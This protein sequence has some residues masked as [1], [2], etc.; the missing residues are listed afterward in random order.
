MNIKQF[1]EGLQNQIY[2]NPVDYAWSYKLREHVP[3]ME[4]SLMSGN[5]LAAA[6]E[7]LSQLGQQLHQA[8]AEKDEITAFHSVRAIMDWGK[9]YYPQGPRRMNQLSVESLFNNGL[10]VQEVSRNW[11]AIKSADSNS[12]TLMNSAWTKVWA[13]L[14]PQDFII[15]DDRVCAAFGL[16]VADFA[17]LQPDSNVTTVAKQLDFYQTA[18]AKKRTI[19]GIPKIHNRKPVW[20]RSMY[21]V[22]SSLKVVVDKSFSEGRNHCDNKIDELR[23]CEA[24][25]FMRGA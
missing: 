11:N 24:Q 1:V 21:V 13:V 15:L 10:L 8:L 16:Y 9:V 17:S 14:G 20:V 5:T 23:F 19:E 18:H 2:G 12:V 22:A 6:N 7:L 3:G 25:L 4:V